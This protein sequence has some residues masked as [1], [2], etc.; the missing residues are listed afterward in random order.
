MSNISCDWVTIFNT[1]DKSTSFHNN[2]KNWHDPS[3]NGVNTFITSFSD[4][5]KFIEIIRVEYSFIFCIE[6]LPENEQQKPTGWADARLSPQK[7]KFWQ[8]CNLNC[9]NTLRTMTKQW[10]STIGSINTIN[11]FICKTEPLPE[12][13]QRVL[14][15]W[16]KKAE[17]SLYFL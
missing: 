5:Y 17:F 7:S 4:S 15:S 8:R 16:R 10:N 11:S 14:P 1:M 13:E 6:F 12:K 9:C 2:A 3:S